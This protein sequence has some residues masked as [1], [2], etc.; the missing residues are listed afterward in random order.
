MSIKQN[1]KKWPLFFRAKIVIF[2]MFFKRLC[3]ESFEDL[4]FNSNWKFQTRAAL[5]HK[6]AALKFFFAKLHKS[7]LLITS[8]V[9]GTASSLRLFLA[10]ECPWKMMKNAFCFMLANYICYWQIEFCSDYTFWLN[11]MSDIR[12]VWKYWSLIILAI[13]IGF[14]SILQ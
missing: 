11:Q 12:E 7:P 6:I 13:N 9:K 2:D 4:E 5:S 10:T 14:R 1:L 8:I 3:K